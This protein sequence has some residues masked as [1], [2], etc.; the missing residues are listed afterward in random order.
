MKSRKQKEKIYNEKYKDIP[1]DYLERLNWMYDK[2]HLNMKKAV[3]IIKKRNEMLET[4]KYEKD[5][6]IVLYEEPEGAH[7]PRARYINKTNLVSSSLSSPGYIQIYSLTGASDREYM[8]RLVETNE[9]QEFQN[10]LI[11]TPCYVDY[12]A[13]FH[14][15]SNWNVTDTYLA[16]IGLIRPITKP[17]F[18]NI[19]KKYADMYNGNIW[20]DDMLVVS[21]KIDKYYSILP[22]IEISLHYLNMLYNKYQYRQIQPRLDQ[23]AQ[24]Y[25]KEDLQ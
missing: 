22:R 19:E 17:D 1:T 8:H 16:E 6:F 12:R 24:Y 13:Y 4:L 10:H 14:T 18:D 15:P 5:F 21:A 20:L 9:L 23:E 7:R 2:Y 11:Y 3:N 25:K